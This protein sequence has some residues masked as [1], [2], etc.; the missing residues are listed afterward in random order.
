MEDD[1]SLLAE[2]GTATAVSSSAVQTVDEKKRTFLKASGVLVG[3]A[4]VS[5]FPHRAKALVL[6][7]TPST[8]VVGLKDASNARV[9]PATDDTLQ[10]VW[11]GLPVSKHTASLSSSGNVYAPASGKSIRLYNNKFSLTA[12]LT[13][14]SFRFGSGGSDF[15]IYLA[16]VTGGLYG[17]NNHPNFVQGGV[18]QPLYCVI[19]GSGTVQ[20]NIDYLEV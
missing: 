1:A 2:G 7:S 9:N 10:S 6:G 14:V 13:S 3:L 19:S 20:V 15:E 5:L 12:N 8:S 16:P 18:D 17:T 11:E 4:A